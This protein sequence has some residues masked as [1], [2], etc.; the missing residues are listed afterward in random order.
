MTF[1][2]EAWKIPNN[3]QNIMGNHFMNVIIISYY[4]WT[5]QSPPHSR[6]PPQPH[7]MLLAPVQQQLQSGYYMNIVYWACLAL[8]TKVALNTHGP[9]WTC[10]LVSRACC[11]ALATLWFIAWQLHIH[12]MLWK[13]FTYLIERD[14]IKQ[15]MDR[16]PSIVY[17]NMLAACSFWFLNQTLR[18]SSIR[19]IDQSP[20]FSMLRLS[21]ANCLR[22]ASSAHNLQQRAAWSVQHALQNAS[23]R[24][25]LQFRLATNCF[26]LPLS[27]HDCCCSCASNINTQTRS[28]SHGHWIKVSIWATSS[29]AV[30]VVTSSTSS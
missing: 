16:L 26:F 13:Y 1:G 25:G 11:L 21:I 30:A 27:F 6:S 17:Y 19:K 20:R 28:H 7:L 18:K 23:V 8:L 4:L 9:S 24:W 22:P 2:V 14:L 3:N 10:Q 29:F 12:Q 5:W 15:A